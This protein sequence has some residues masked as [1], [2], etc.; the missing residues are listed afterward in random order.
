M[1]STVILPWIHYVAV[2]ALSGAIF[3]KLYLMKLPASA[4][5]VRLLPR[6]DRLEGT[7]AVIVFVTV[8][9][10]RVAPPGGGHRAEQVRRGPVPVGAGRLPAHDQEPAA[11]PP[12]RGSGEAR[13]PKS[14]HPSAP[15]R[16][17]TSASG[18]E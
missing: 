15:P 16:A 12:G 10:R 17:S 13:C 6:I 2:I 9:P 7:S 1:F 5:I 14:S 4:D 11:R 18:P 8:P 3:A